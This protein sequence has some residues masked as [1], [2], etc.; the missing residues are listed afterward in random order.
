MKKSLLMAAILVA[1]STLSLNAIAKE[2][3]PKQISYRQGIFQ[4]CYQQYA[5]NPYV[6]KIPEND[7]IMMDTC[8]C[9][10]SHITS[11]FFANDEKVKRME[12][13]DFNRYR[14]EVSMRAM[15]SCGVAQR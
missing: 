6:P 11:E 13:M 5:N 7:R 2:L 9:L 10:T 14:I 4:R 8:S 3:T 1:G 12:I 15:A